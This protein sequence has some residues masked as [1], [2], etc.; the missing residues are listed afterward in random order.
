M[1]PK[2]TLKPLFAGV[3]FAVL[4]GCAGAGVKSGQYLDDAAI[5]GK[6]KAALATDKQV[7][8]LD[9]HVDTV[10]GKVQLSG[11]VK[12]PEQRQRAEEIARSVAGV[13]SVNNSLAVSAN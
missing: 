3:L 2:T 6:V 9:V 8:A 1:M 12:S 4:A 5:T 13:Q 10:Q 11:A 7:S